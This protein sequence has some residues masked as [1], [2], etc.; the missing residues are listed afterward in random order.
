V[1][2]DREKVEI[3]LKNENRESFLMAEIPIMP[4]S[5]RRRRSAMPSS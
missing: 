4:A 2:F 1:E 3:A 5:E